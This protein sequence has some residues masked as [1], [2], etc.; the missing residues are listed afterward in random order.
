MGFVVVDRVLLRR[1]SHCWREEE[2]TYALVPVWIAK[3]NHITKLLLHRSG[4]LGGG[5]GSGSRGGSSRG[6]LGEDGSKGLLGSRGSGGGSSGSSGGW[7]LADLADLELGGV[8]LQDALI[9]VFPELLG[10]VLAA[11]ALENLLSAGVLVREPGRVREEREEEEE[12]H[13][14]TS[15]T[16][17]SM[18]M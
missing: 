5:R 7:S 8:F 14:V 18:M 10:G 3:R 16:W 4:N 11:Y 1:V 15:K 9:V 2:E 13:L 12:T 6:S 17:L